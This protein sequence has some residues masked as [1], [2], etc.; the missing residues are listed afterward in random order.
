MIQRYL[1]APPAWLQSDVGTAILVV[2][3][4]VLV[5]VAVRLIL[6]RRR[7]AALAAPPPLL[8]PTHPRGPDEEA[9]PAG[10]SQAEEVT[11]RSIEMSPGPALVAAAPVPPPAGQPTNGNGSHDANVT[12]QLLPGRLEPG[13]AATTQEIRFVRVPGSNRFT[14]GRHPGPTH[15]HIQ[16]QSATASR[17]HAFMVYEDGRWR[18]GN[19]SNTNRVIVNGAPI[20]TEEPRLLNDGDRIEFGELVFVFRDR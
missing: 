5:G 9:R 6:T 3:A 19:M 12:L 18:I 17:M 1:P 11:Y 15:T 10:V 4:L 16:L 2:V 14:L 13:N 20:E 8:Y 7:Q